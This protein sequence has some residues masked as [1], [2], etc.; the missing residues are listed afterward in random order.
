MSQQVIDMFEVNLDPL[1]VDLTTFLRR[2]NIYNWE[3]KSPLIKNLC[4]SKSFDM[5]LPYY[6]EE[7]EGEQE[8]WLQESILFTYK[9][10]EPAEH[11]NPYMQ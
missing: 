2:D 9:D 11:E 3:Y 4:R 5:R 8:A 1:Y 10:E 6:G 7:D